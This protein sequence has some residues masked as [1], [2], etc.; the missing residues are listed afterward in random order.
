MNTV[1][2]NGNGWKSDVISD[3]DKTYCEKVAKHLSDNYLNAVWDVIYPLENPKDTVKLQQAYGQVKESVIKIR[4][5]ELTGKLF[6]FLRL[7][8]LEKYEKYPTWNDVKAIIRYKTIYKC[9]RTFREF[10]YERKSG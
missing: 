1:Y 5:R 4:E 6:K 8:K 7:Q 2:K 3:Y 10:L 9:K